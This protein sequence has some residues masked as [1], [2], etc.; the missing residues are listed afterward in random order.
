MRG[1][2]S[3]LVI[4]SAKLLYEVMDIIEKNSHITYRQQGLSLCFSLSVSHSV[5]LCFVNINLNLDFYVVAIDDEIILFLLMFLCCCCCCCCW[6]LLLLFLDINWKLFRLCLYGRHPSHS[7]TR[8]R[9]WV[10]ERHCPTF[11][12]HL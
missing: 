10:H 8:G 9:D 5:C 1:L 6:L 3:G 4:I 2:V 11:S 7:C 12:G